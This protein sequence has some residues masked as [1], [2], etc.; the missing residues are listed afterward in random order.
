MYRYYVN[1]VRINEIKKNNL[2]EEAPYDIIIRSRGDTR[3]I[4]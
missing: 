2:C 3:K 4:K 1:K